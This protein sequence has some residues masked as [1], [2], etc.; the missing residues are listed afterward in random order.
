M[1][2]L[3]DFDVLGFSA[4]AAVSLL[5]DA[6]AK[7]VILLALV[8]LALA[9]WRHSSAAMRHM[10]WSLAI[11]GLLTL[12][13]TSWALPSWNILPHWL[14][15]TAAGSLPTEYGEAGDDGWAPYS[16]PPH[17]DESEVAIDSSGQSE[18]VLPESGMPASGPAEIESSASPGQG[19]AAVP[20]A[21][22]RAV[23]PQVPEGGDPTI[24][25]H[26]AQ[27]ETAAAPAHTE[28]L[29]SQFQR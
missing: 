23:V 9:C 4:T 28:L 7:G 17:D 24:G 14:D 13:I 6:I 10:V 27:Q 26:A 25:D 22:G 5:G 19:V 3:A 16:A 11:V 1:F 20:P 12:P 2:C 18:G 15:L 21:V 29:T 8:A